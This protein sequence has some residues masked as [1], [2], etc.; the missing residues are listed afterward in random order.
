MATDPSYA[1]NTTTQPAAVTGRTADICH[2]IGFKYP[3][4]KTALPA[5]SL[6]V[7]RALPALLQLSEEGLSLLDDKRTLACKGQTGSGKTILYGSFHP[8]QYELKLIQS[9]IA[10]Q[11]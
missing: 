11:F 3:Y 1:A 6:A 8:F 7:M 2:V 4:Q 5:E 10:L 9:L